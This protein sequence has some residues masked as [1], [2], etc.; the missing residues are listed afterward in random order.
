MDCN[1]CPRNCKVNRTQTPGFCGMSNN[2]KLSKVGKFEWEEPVIS[3][4]K[5]SGAIFFSG[6]NL[7]CV[8]CQNYKISSEGFGREITVERLIQIFKELENQNVHNINLVSPTQFSE[9]IIQALQIYKPKIPV[10]WNS[11]G[12]ENVSE[13]KKL[14]GL[15]DIYLVDCK[16]KNSE[17]S[18]KYCKAENYFEVNA[19]CINE[20][21]RQQP[22]VI[23]DKEN[24]MQKGVIIRHLV[25]PNCV[26]DSID[27]LKYLTSIYKDNFLLSIMGQ[28]TPFYRAKDYPEINRKLKPL[29]YKMVINKAIEFG[30]NEGFVQDLK[31]ATEDFIPKFDLSGV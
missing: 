21:L 24:I 17:L 18:K 15:I 7:K 13:I 9:Q 19:V 26:Y 11:N 4:T 3:G 16:F 20:M 6:C 25:M 29:E 28:Y 27:I 2:L 10:V 31:S 22:A 12:Y 23:L 30:L 1:I 8:F 5:G 14:Q